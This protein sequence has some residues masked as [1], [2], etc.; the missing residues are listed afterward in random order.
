[1]NAI[2]EQCPAKG[3]KLPVKRAAL[4]ELAEICQG[5]SPREDDRDY[6][7]DDTWE[8]IDNFR[9]TDT[10][11]PDG[12]SRGRSAAKFQFEST[13]FPGVELE[14]TM[15]GMSK[16]LELLC[17]ESSGFTLHNGGI[18]GTWTFVKQGSDISVT[19]SPNPPAA[20]TGQPDA[21]SQG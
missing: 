20:S 11:Q 19:P 9:F 8:F 14:F 16:V 7:H 15:S 12:Y 13:L 17:Q 6:Y 1:M 2:I 18:H 21:N 3:W 4:G 10:L 5:Y